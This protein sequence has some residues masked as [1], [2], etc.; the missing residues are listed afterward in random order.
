[1]IRRMRFRSRSLVDRVSL[2]LGFFGGH[3][4]EVG[5]KL[6]DSHNSKLEG[7]ST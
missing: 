3:L 6:A 4:E 1:M 7:T 5:D 2:L